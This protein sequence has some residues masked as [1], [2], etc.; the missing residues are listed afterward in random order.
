MTPTRRTPM[1]RPTVGALAAG[2]LVLALAAC[3]GGMS[4]MS[5]DQDTTG[6]SAPEAAAGDLADGTAYSAG[7]GS[8]VAESR[9]SGRADQGGGATLDLT[10]DQE[11][12]EP[13]IISVGT[14]SLRADDVGDARFEVRKITDRLEGQVTDEETNTDDE[15]TIKNSRLVLRIPADSFDEA[16]QQLSE[17]ADFEASSIG[18]DDV[19]TQ[20]VDTEVRIRVQRASI[21]R[22]A[23]LLDRAQSIRDIVSIEGQLTRRQ[24]TLNSLLRRQAYLADQTSLS[25]ITVH[26][27]R[28]AGEPEKLDDDTRDSGFLAGLDA[29]W[30]G[31]VSVTVGLATVTGAVLPFGVVLLVVGVPALLV[32]RRRRGAAAIAAAGAQP[33]A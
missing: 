9:E 17:V 1:T 6:A 2:A 22:I 20:V 30:D 33:S 19:T 24:A 23:V 29:G 5:E 26:L 4:T 3:S 11:G 27:E 14:V 28:P 13:A 8:T 18:E 12:L 31:L 15:G 16:M 21:R 7:L 32:V 10:G 25:T